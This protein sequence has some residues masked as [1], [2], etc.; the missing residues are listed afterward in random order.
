MAY[1]NRYDK[2]NAFYLEMWGLLDQFF[3]EG[4]WLDFASPPQPELYIYAQRLTAMRERTALGQRLDEV[5]YEKV[6]RRNEAKEH[7]RGQYLNTLKSI[8][9]K[10]DQQ[11]TE[12]QEAGINAE[13]KAG[14]EVDKKEL[15]DLLDEYGTMDS[16]IAAWIERAC[17]LRERIG[18]KALDYSRKIYSVEGEVWER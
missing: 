12:L 3:P 14:A 10:V 11:F 4:R 1:S 5:L 7:W 9:T 8:K 16:D 17:R 6:N 13:E 15:F 2:L 18:D